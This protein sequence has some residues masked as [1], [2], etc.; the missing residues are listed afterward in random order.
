MTLENAAK[1]VILIRTRL[2]FF[3]KTVWGS[4]W[5]CSRKNPQIAAFLQSALVLPVPPPPSIHRLHT[6]AGRPA[7]FCS[8]PP[9]YHPDTVDTTLS[10]PLLSFTTHTDRSHVRPFQSHPWNISSVTGAPLVGLGFG[11]VDCS[12]RSGRLHLST[13]PIYTL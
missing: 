12:P 4:H 9:P 8:E 13:P 1:N 2:K 3:W 10:R 11:I 6:P 7:C 5:R